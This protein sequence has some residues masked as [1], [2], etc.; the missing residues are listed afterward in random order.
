MGTRWNAYK[1]VDQP[2][3]E[4]LGPV[5]SQSSCVLRFSRRL[6][7]RDRVTPERRRC[8]EWPELRN[9]CRCDPPTAACNLY[10]HGKRHQRL[11]G[12]RRTGGWVRGRHPARTCKLIALA[13]RSPHTARRRR[14]TRGGLHCSLEFLGEAGIQT[15]DRPVRRSVTWQT[16][17]GA[18][19]GSAERVPVRRVRAIGATRPLVPPWGGGGG[20][21]L[22]GSVWAGFC[23]SSAQCCCNS[24]FTALCAS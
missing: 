15:S 12:S 21:G 13:S 10:H 2:L 18:R 17:G 14:C 5:T 6:L 23:V 7:A 8:P 22:R 20:S 1:A 24:S 9:N 16:R 3:R 19:S 11:E 4:P